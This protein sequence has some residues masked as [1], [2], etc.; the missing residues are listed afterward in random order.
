MWTWNL[1]YIEAEKSGRKDQCGLM[2]KVK[3]I[4][5][6]SLSEFNNPR[7]KLYKDTVWGEM[8]ISFSYERN[9]T[10]E[11]PSFHNWNRYAV[12]RTFKQLELER[13]VESSKKYIKESKEKNKKKNKKEEE[14]KARGS[15]DATDLEELARFS[16]SSVYRLRQNPRIAPRDSLRFNLQIGAMGFAQ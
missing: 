2:V 3:K 12:T 8:Y 5:V 10:F 6:Y 1:R 9:F 7:R 4:S 13:K 16:Q 15:S 14:S 11:Q